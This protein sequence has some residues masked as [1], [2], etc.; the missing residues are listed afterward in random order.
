MLMANYFQQKRE[1][2]SDK[3]VYEKCCLF[4]SWG[5]KEA[6]TKQL[7]YLIQQLKQS[8]KSQATQTSLLPEAL[9]LLGSWMWNLRSHSS[10]AILED[11]FLESIR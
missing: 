8:H 3:I 4:W 2:L 6:A 5:Q 1:I 9:S 10:S 7:D 11:C